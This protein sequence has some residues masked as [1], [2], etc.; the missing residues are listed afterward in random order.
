MDQVKV[1]KFIAEQRKK[2]N[3]THTSWTTS[4]ERSK[5]YD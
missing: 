1:G 2:K 3:L 5:N 4:D